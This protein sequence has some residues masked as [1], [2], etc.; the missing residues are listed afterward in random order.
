G[1]LRGGSLRDAVANLDVVLPD[2][3]LLKT[4]SGADAGGALADLTPLFFGAEGT[5]GIVT[6]AVLRLIPKPELTRPLT[7]S[8]PELPAAGRFLKA[9]VDA[10]LTPITPRPWTATTSSSSGRSAPTPRSPSTWP[11]S[12]CRVP[13]TRSRTR[14]RPSTRSRRKR[15]AP[16]SRRRSGTAYGASDTTT[17]ARDDS[18]AAS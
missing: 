18:A 2:G 15:E 11:S 5:L 8:F 9:I 16:S 7:Y 10:G 4:A 13:R 12:R 1:G 17:T 14:R 3:S 6:K